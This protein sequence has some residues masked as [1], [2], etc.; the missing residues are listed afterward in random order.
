MAGRKTNWLNNKLLDWRFRG[1][2]YTPPT[3]YLFALI[4]ATA[5]VSPRNTAVTLNQTTVPNSHNG[6]MYKC[7]TAGTTGASEPTWPTTDGGT[8]TDG[9]A[10]WTEMNADFKS[11]S[12]V[13][14]GAEVS[15]GNY[16]RVSVNTTT[17]NFA[18]T[19]G[20]GST[21]NPSSGTS[22]STSNNI[23]ITFGVPS[24]NWGV[25]GANVLLDGSGN[26]HQW[27]VLTNPKTVNNGDPAPSWPAG[28]WAYYEE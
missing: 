8:V 6:R 10:V 28:A 16:S 25:I 17:T 5:G 4:R 14:S 13:V 15:G 21:T 2:T 24:A 3:A 19:N 1:V 22:D 27:N 18:A 11:Y 9:T 12:S 23:A 26:A 20:A 7:T